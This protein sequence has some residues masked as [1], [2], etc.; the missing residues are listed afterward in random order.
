MKNKSYKKSFPPSTAVV[1][2]FALSSLFSQVAFAQDFS[3]LDNDL[4]QLEN[5]IQDT[6][7]NTAPKTARACVWMN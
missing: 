7:A 2:L 4:A 3:S 1:L 6:I 5:L